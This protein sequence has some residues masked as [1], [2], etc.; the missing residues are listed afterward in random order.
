MLKKTQGLDGR[1]LG[2]G[3]PQDV[4]GEQGS[5][6]GLGKIVLFSWLR[7]VGTGK[8]PTTE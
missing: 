3:T 5:G 4:A 2:E 1:Q 6:V 8:R 7:G